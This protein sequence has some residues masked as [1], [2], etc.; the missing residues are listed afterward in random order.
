MQNTYHDE[1]GDNDGNTFNPVDRG[2]ARHSTRTKV[3][4]ET[5]SQ[6]DY[7]GNGKEDL[8][9]SERQRRVR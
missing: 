5:E 2:F 3:L 8:G 4:E 1:N 9:R 6:G 7:C